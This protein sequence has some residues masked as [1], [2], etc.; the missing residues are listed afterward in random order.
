MSKADEIVYAIK[1]KEGKYATYGRTEF[2]DRLRFA[3]LYKSK[4]TALQH[5]FNNTG[6][7]NDLKLVKIEIKI[8]DEEELKSNEFSENRG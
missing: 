2:K 4:K 6:D 1:N 5:Y 3:K 7:Y 8:L